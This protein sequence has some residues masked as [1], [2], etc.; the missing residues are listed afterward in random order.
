[1]KDGTYEA[2]ITGADFFALGKS[3]TPVL[4]VN[5]EVYDGSAVDS[6]NARYWLTPKAEWRAKKMLRHFG[7]TWED[8]AQVC[9]GP[10]SPLAGRKCQVKITNKEYNGR[11]DPEA[12]IILP[13]NVPLT[14]KDVMSARAAPPEP[15]PAPAPH[16]PATDLGAKLAQETP[17]DDI[18]F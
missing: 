15:P 4:I 2:T 12:E 1:M 7:F 10:N 9:G 11:P 8:R 17:F 5:L 18:P 3:E 16:P 14:P 6:A 13:Q